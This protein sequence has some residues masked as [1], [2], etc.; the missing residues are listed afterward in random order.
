MHTTKIT[1]IVDREHQDEVLAFI[2]GIGT[3]FDFSRLIPRPTGMGI[4]PSTE[5]S[6]MAI[7]FYLDSIGVSD[8]VHNFPA[9]RGEPWALN[10]NTQQVL[11]VENLSRETALAM[12]RQYVETK[13]KYG[14]YDGW[15]WNRVNWGSETGAIGAT[16]N[17]W[18]GGLKSVAFTT[19]VS[20][21]L[22]AFPLPIVRKLSSEFPKARFEFH[23]LYE[24]AVEPMRYT[25]RDGECQI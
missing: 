12:G 11:A 15:E 23:V 17:E 2:K 16:V 7:A 21:P 3:P 5:Q 9:L 6:E 19:A 4:G 20:Y 8:G 13:L 25:F 22:P 1:M 18:E 10:K 14:A 24:E